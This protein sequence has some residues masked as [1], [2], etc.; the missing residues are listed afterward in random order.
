VFGWALTAEE[1]NNPI[2]QNVVHMEE[3][4]N[5]KNDGIQGVS[6]SKQQVDWKKNLKNMN[7]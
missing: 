5:V 2:V 6:H 1:K 4:Y 3:Q 7:G